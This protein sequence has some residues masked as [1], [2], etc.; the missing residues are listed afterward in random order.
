[1]Q[2]WRGFPADFIKPPER[3]F[4]STAVKSTLPAAP[5]H[6]VMDKIRAEQ[7][8]GKVCLRLK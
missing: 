4:F 1:L 3:T 2:Q 7:N 5:L 8:L 6:P